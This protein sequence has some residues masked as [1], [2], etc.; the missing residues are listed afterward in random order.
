MEK[1][2]RREG[3]EDQLRFEV[4]IHCRSSLRYL[5]GLFFFLIYICMTSHMYD[6]NMEIATNAMD[7]SLHPP[8]TFGFTAHVRL[9][10][11]LTFQHSATIPAFLLCQGEGED[12]VTAVS[13]ASIPVGLPG[14]PG[15]LLSS[16]EGHKL[17]HQRLDPK[18][19]P[20]IR[21][22]PG[23]TGKYCQCFL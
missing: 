15:S 21:K 14:T 12:A 5:S 20:R 6:L 19:R 4:L 9:W 22:S 17:T 18:F 1:E 2:G 16:S 3:K 13:G 10:I 11:E 8:I 23:Q 7:Y